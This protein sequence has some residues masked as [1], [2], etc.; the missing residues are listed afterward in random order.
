MRKIL[1]YGIIS[2]M[3]LAV[4]GAGTLFVRKKAG[5]K[6]ST[7]YQMVFLG[8]SLFGQ[9]RD[10]T[11]VSTRVGE[12]LGLS[13]FNG[14]FG[15]TDAARIASDQGLSPQKGLLSLD[16]LAVA[17]TTGEFGAQRTLRIRENGTAHFSATIEELSAIDLKQADILVLEY[18]TNDYFDGVP[19]YN[20]ENPLD[21]YS[22][23]GALKGAIQ[24][25]Q[26]KYPDIRILMVSPT[27]HWITSQ[28]Q[29]CEQW[30]A[31]G[32][33]LAEYVAVEQQ[34]AQETGIEF[35]DIYHDFYPHET[36]EEYLTYTLDGV[37]PN[38]AGREKIAGKIAEYLT[39]TGKE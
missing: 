21:G 27:Y 19:L 30:N 13:A 36:W 1:S 35:L 14:C 20:E 33:L 15:G 7:A 17:V 18:G 32:G 9:I 6:N 22:F 37:H 16:A 12:L 8:D 24:R 3:I 4:L 11:S 29:T 25:I 5:A 10:E 2:V 28:G 39:E 31:G 34:V 26:H 23:Y 38:D